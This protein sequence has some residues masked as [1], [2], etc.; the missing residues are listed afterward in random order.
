MK[1]AV[2]WVLVMVGFALFPVA[3]QSQATAD[4]DKLLPINEGGRW[5]V[6]DRAGKVILS[7]VYDEVWVSE[8]TMLVWGGGAWVPSYLNK[9]G[10]FIWKPP[11]VFAMEDEDIESLPY[12][13]GPFRE[14]LARVIEGGLAGFIDKSGKY[15]IEP[16]FLGARD[17]SEGL[18]AVADLDDGLWGYIGRNGAYVIPPQFFEAYSFHE[19]MAPAE[20]DSKHGYIDKSGKVVIKAQFAMV[21]NFSEG[22]ASVGVSDSNEK[23]LP[24]ILGAASFK[25][26]WGYVDSSG[27]TIITAQFEEARPFSEGL[28]AVKQAGLWGF[29]DKKGKALIGPKYEDAYGFSEGLAAVKQ[30]GRWGYIDKAGALVLSPRFDNAGDFIDGLA[31]VWLNEKMGYIYK[32][33]EYFWRASK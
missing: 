24:G 9:N 27:K 31:A 2:I 15:A 25:G 29:I 32:N 23:P 19:G 10:G 4:S 20:I 14:G 1:A 3:S 22:L 17:F 12:T 13:L 28:A 21:G 16:Q 5:G 6:M 7:P 33:G 18:A 8:G 26:K 30:G 11:D